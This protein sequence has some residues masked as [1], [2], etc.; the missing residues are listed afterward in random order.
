[1]MIA[2][3]RL[4]TLDEMLNAKPKHAPVLDVFMGSQ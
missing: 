2:G 4:H 1:M 3:K